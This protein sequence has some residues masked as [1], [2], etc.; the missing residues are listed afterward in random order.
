MPSQ[1]DRSRRHTWTLGP[2]FEGLHSIPPGLHLV[3]F[4]PAGNAAGREG[5]WIR[6]APG[7]VSRVAWDP[8]LEAV[9]ATDPLDAAAAAH[10][11]NQARAGRLRLGPYV[12][13]RGASEDGSG[14]LRGHSAETSRGGA[15]AATWTFRGDESRRR[16]GHEMDIPWRRVAAAP[17]PRRGYFAEAR[18]GSVVRGGGTGGSVTKT[19]GAGSRLRRGRDVDIPRGDLRRAFYLSPDLRRRRERRTSPD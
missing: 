1:R 15:A 9:A 17:R 8:A 2:D 13:P 11:E 18:R 7:G 6:V 16:R 5:V 4:A 19:F 10:L 14:R 3:T 12:S